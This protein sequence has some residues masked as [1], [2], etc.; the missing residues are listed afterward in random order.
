MDHQDCSELLAPFARGELDR[1]R[2]LEVE[3]HL[4]GCAECSA[5]LRA[6]LALTSLP[7][8]VPTPDERRALR[9]AIRPA[10]PAWRMRLA[11]ALG[12]AATLVIVAIGIGIFVTRDDGPTLSADAPADTS[13]DVE[14]GAALDDA[15]RDETS[16]QNDAEALESQPFSAGGGGAQGGAA[17]TDLV[18]GDGFATADLGPHLLEMTTYYARARNLA[19]LAPDDEWAAQMRACVQAIS[20]TSALPSTPA[21][22][23]VF[24]AE[25]LLVMGFRF[26]AGTGE[27]YAFYGWWRGEC[28][29][30]TPIYVAGSL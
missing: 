8:A 28:S 24:V 5:E 23:R 6:I 14:G 1:A 22:A 7:S 12:A 17:S 3:E 13:T 10:R 26:G 20:T 2:G 21:F 4:A 11:P 15:G 30:P 19:A 18:A 25:D 27:S 16:N 9:T 29:H